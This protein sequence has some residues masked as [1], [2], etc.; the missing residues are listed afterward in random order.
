MRS[1]GP[2]LRA[3]CCSPALI[4]ASLHGFR[5]WSSPRIRICSPSPGASS[6]GL[7]CFGPMRISPGSWRTDLSR[8]GKLAGRRVDRL[9]PATVGSDS[10]GRGSRRAEGRGD[11]DPRLHGQRWSAGRTGRTSGRA[12]CGRPVHRRSPGNEGTLRLSGPAGR[13][14]LRAS[15]GVCDGRS[16]AAAVARSTHWS[17]RSSSSLRP[18]CSD[19]ARASNCR[20]AVL[21][22]RRAWAIG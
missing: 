2:G 19:M 17:K 5:G 14:G 3:G 1:P 18:A 13:R 16:P 22:S 7:P 10:P 4:T 11:S 6:R 9:P 12:R 8:L 15:Q 20:R 21:T